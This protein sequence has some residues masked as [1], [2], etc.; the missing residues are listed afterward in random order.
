MA[1]KEFLNV[2]VKNC[3]TVESAQ[4]AYSLL[5]TNQQLD[6]IIL[7]LYLPDAYGKDI[8]QKIRTFE[9][10]K[11]T[12]VIIYSGKTISKTEQKELYKDAFAIV[13]KNINSYKVLLEH[14]SKIINDK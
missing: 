7:D 12:P 4:E 9:D 3:I 8:L 1:L 14:I 11:K 2:V 6:C 13:Q 10:Y 5:K